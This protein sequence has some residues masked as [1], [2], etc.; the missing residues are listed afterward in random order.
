MNLL[1][2]LLI[3]AVSAYVLQLILSGVQIENFWTAIIFAVV[4]GIVNLIFKPIMQIL[5]FPLT[6]LT[7]GLFALVIN[8]LVIMIVDYF[9]DGM[10]VDGFGWAFIFSILL[11]IITSVIGGVVNKD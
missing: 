6:V 3:T 1:V 8:A 5:G 9:V 2:R 7:L 11:S 4:L 10:T